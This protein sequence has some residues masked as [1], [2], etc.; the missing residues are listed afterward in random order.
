[1]YDK[2][3]SQGNTPAVTTSL[4]TP[5]QAEMSERRQKMLYFGLLHAL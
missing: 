2:N 3:S 1:M 4:I 5:I